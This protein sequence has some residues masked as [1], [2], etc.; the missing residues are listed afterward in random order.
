M[1]VILEFLYSVCAKK[2]K[3][4]LNRHSDLTNHLNA[5]AERLSMRIHNHLMNIISST[6]STDLEKEILDD[7]IQ[8]DFDRLIMQADKKIILGEQSMP[9]VTRVVNT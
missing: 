7:A 9:W 8:A 5:E 2:L 6:K 4:Q 3:D 1:S